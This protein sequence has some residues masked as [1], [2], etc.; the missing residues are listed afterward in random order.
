MALRATTPGHLPKL[1]WTLGPH[2]PLRPAASRVD[3][4]RRPAPTH[5]E[6]AHGAAWAGTA[7]CREAPSLCSR[8]YLWLWTRDPSGHVSRWG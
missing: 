8:T 4:G 1:P 7:A 5:G 6:G 3:P 2:A